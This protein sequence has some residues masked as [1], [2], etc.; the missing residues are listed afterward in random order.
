M[1]SAR[2]RRRPETSLRI[3]ERPRHKKRHSPGHFLGRQCGSHSDFHALGSNRRGRVHPGP[4]GIIDPDLD[5]GV[6]IGLTNNQIFPKRIDLTAEISTHDTGRHA[7]N[8]HQKSK[9]AG[10]VFAVS[11]PGIKDKF[12]DGVLPE[13]RRFQG[14]YKIVFPKIVQGNPHNPRRIAGS[15]LLKTTGQIP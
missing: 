1:I 15:L 12:I 4:S 8:T 2:A 9:G 7:G 13:K 6:R 5:P 10:I 14:V 3:I 11:S